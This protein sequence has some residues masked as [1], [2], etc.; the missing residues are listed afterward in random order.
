MTNRWLKNCTMDGAV[1]DKLMNAGQLKALSA[2]EYSLC[3]A[4]KPQRLYIEVK[5]V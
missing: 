3:I 4:L 2:V 1:G 5:A